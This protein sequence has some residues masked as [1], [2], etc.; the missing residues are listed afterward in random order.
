MTGT[1]RLPGGKPLKASQRG[2]R[3][4]ALSSRVEIPWRPGDKVRWRDRVGVYRRD[5]GEEHAEIVL[6]SGRVYRVRISELQ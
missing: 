6:G 2:K 5:V 3:V 1:S 4:G